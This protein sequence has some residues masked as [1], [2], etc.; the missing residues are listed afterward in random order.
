MKNGTRRKIIYTVS[1]KSSKNR[2]KIEDN[3]SDKEVSDITLR[4]IVCLGVIVCVA[5]VIGVISM[6]TNYLG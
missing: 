2:L 3:N 6:I 4:V 1:P 5:S